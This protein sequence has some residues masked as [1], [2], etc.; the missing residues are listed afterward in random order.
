MVIIGMGTDLVRVSRIAGVL[1]RFGER[2]LR[3]TYHPS[4]IEQYR[5]RA[6]GN[7]QRGVEYLASRWAIK[8]A[9]YKVLSGRTG[10]RV[11]FPEI[12]SRSSTTGTG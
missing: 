9:A 6:E 8:E 3:R 12:V 5:T 1:G 10:I 2:F 7:R 4:E 11:P